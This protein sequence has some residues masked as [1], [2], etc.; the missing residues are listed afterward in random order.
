MSAKGFLLFLFI[1]PILSL[2]IIFSFIAGAIWHVFGTYILLMLAG[3]LAYKIY[4]KLRK[5]K[6]SK[7]LKV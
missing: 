7:T 1:V 6:Q 2:S 4:L 3:W 5:T